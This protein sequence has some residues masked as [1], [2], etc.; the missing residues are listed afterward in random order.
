MNFK[1]TENPI[2]RSNKI[3]YLKCVTANDSFEKMQLNLIKI[4][5]C[6][7]QKHL[8]YLYLHMYSDVCYRFSIMKKKCQII[9]ST[10]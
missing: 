1:V 10:F 5:E 8:Q 2:N 6:V 4:Y 7:L 3:L 9:K